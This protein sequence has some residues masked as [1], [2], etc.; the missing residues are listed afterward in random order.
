MEKI[1]IDC[2]LIMLRLLD[3]LHSSGKISRTEYDYHVKEKRDFLE[4]AGV[5]VK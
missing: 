5:F 1:L 2:C 4:R 3:D